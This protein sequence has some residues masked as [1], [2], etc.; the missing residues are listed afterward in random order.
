MEDFPQDLILNILSR[1]PVKLLIQSRCV[2]KLWC[3][4]VDSQCLASMHLRQGSE[5]PSLLLVACPTG[6]ASI[7]SLYLLKEDR[8][9]LRTSHNATMQI[10]NSRKYGPWCSCNGLLCFARHGDG[11]LSSRHDGRELVFICNPLRG[12]VLTLPPITTISP[13][14]VGQK[15]GLGY[16]PSTKE[17]KVVRIFYHAFDGINDQYSFG[18]E[19]YTL[20]SKSWRDVRSTPPYAVTGKPVFAEGSLHWMINSE[21][22]PNKT[23]HVILSFNIAREEFSVMPHPD[24]GL[25]NHDMLALVDLGGSL[26]LVDSSSDKHILIWVL[27]DYNKRC[28]LREYC[29]SIKAP[30]GWSGRSNNGHIRV[31]GFWE[32]GEILLTSS[33]DSFFSFNPRT[34]ALRYVHVS[35]LPHDIARSEVYG[36]TGSLVSL[37]AYDLT[38]KIDVNAVQDSCNLEATAQKLEQ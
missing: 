37:K 17:Y 36:H 33:E 38:A 12:D 14:P 2:S 26:S 34:D 23:E 10:L 5:E 35:V 6:K 27:K 25:K 4:L 11:L 16:Y 29:I 3:N 7:T 32:H 18:A 9:T 15:Y 31:I 22:H 24:I 21:L 28:W 8:G 1:L 13:V 19:I 30:E 20:R